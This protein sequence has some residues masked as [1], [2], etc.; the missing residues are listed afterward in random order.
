MPADKVFL[1]SNLLVYLYSHT[2][3]EKANRVIDVIC[4]NN[5]FISTQV[6]NEFSNVCIR[7]L[8][9]AI[10]D[11]KKAISEIAAACHLLYINEN[12]IFLALRIHNEYKYSYYDS[13]MIASALESGCNYLFSEDMSDGQIINSSITI[14]NVFKL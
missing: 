6:L 3:Q 12:D 14:K 7:K 9:F 2:E 1:D 10:S 13:L 4:N 5:C 8:G 11:I